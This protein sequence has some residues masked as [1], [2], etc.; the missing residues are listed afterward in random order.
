VPSNRS[1]GEEGMVALLWGL[2][3]AVHLFVIYNYVM[4]SGKE[5]EDV[6]EAPSVVKKHHRFGNG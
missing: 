6:D 5:L 2:F 3:S 1:G 4:Y